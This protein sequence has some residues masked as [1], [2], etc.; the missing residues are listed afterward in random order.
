MWHI[1]GGIDLVFFPRGAYVASEFKKLG[2]SP[3]FAVKIPKLLLI[4]LIIEL[5][6]KKI[7]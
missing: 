7:H 2:D 3:R 4:F 1:C 5:K 6:V